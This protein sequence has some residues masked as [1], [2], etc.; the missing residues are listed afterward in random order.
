MVFVIILVNILRGLIMVLATV[1]QQLLATDFNGA[2]HGG[3]ILF[4]V[5]NV[6]II[7]VRLVNGGALYPPVVC[8]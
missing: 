8:R 1:V 6:H 2:Q 7:G 5:L 4:L 3:R